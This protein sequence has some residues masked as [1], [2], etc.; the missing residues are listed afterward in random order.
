[1]CKGK[2]IDETKN[3]E[4]DKQKSSDFS[5]I[6]GDVDDFIFSFTDSKHHSEK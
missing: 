5:H 1:M 2:E 3:P 6:K 4:S